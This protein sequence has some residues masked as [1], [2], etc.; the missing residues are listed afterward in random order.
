M[1]HVHAKTR[2]L[3]ITDGRFEEKGTGECM[4]KI[5]QLSSRIHNGPEERPFLEK[6]HIFLVPM[7]ANMMAERNGSCFIHTGIDSLKFRLTLGWKS[8][9]GP[10][11]GSKENHT[12][13]MKDTFFVVHDGDTR[14]LFGQTMHSL[15]L[16]T[17]GS[18][19]SF[20]I[21]KIMRTRDPKNTV[22]VLRTVIQE[23]VSFRM[24]RASN[25]SKKSQCW[26]CR[27]YQLLKGLF[28]EVYEEIASVLKT[29]GR[30]DDRFLSGV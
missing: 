3:K 30:H 18:S 21:G 9:M 15:E 4:S 26:G 2:P 27:L 23:V 22:P 16:V 13:V 8:K 7:I 24:L 19:S 25:I 1:H 11:G 12:V 17:K 14:E 28:R 6:Q 20:C 5:D 10:Q 29:E